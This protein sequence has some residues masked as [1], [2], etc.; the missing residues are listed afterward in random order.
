MPEFKHKFD[1]YAATMHR[2]KRE[3]SKTTSDMLNDE[4]DT[5]NAFINTLRR[6]KLLSSYTFKITDDDM[7]RILLFTDNIYVHQRSEIIS[8]NFEI[9]ECWIHI[10]FDFDRFEFYIDKSDISTIVDEF[11]LKIDT[12]MLT[13]YIGYREKYIN[14]E[15]Q[16]INDLRKLK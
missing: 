13:S 6:E 11:G 16:L 8:T 14:S 3:H 1:T 4:T 10:K 9:N 12:N 2:M 5:I 15:I 7:G